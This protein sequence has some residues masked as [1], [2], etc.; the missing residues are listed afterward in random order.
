MHLFILTTSP[1]NNFV[2]YNG[3]HGSQLARTSF[4]DKM[5]H[6]DVNTWNIPLAKLQLTYFVICTGYPSIVYDFQDCVY[7]VT[8]NF[9]SSNWN[10]Y[11]WN[12]YSTA[13][14]KH[15]QVLW[16]SVLD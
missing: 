4:W 16:S 3:S 7:C 11:N 5:T 6:F 13:R 15:S 14:H 1:T 2:G 12:T 9:V 8:R 10:T